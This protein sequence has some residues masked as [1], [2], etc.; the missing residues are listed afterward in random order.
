[1]NSL[2]L[3]L[4]ASMLATFAAEASAA[5]KSC[6]ISVVGGSWKGK[7]YPIKVKNGQFAGTKGMEDS[8][9]SGCVAKK[10]IYGRWYHLCG[11]GKIIVF[12]REGSAWKR[13]AAKN[14]KKYRHNCL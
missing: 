3:V 2:K 10:K 9:L 13:L 14:L 1:M 7:T 4:A 8:E 11:N 6:K 12:R 5:S